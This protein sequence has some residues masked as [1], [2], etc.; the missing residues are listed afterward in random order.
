MVIII[1]ILVLVVVVLGE[2]QQLEFHLNSQSKFTVMLKII[3]DK[4]GKGTIVQ[5]AKVV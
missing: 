4:N 1:K 5:T 3:R 2:N